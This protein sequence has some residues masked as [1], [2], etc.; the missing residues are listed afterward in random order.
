MGA[1]DD[2]LAGRLEDLELPEQEIQRALLEIE[3]LP[4]PG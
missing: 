1:Y 4:K 3:A 2:Y